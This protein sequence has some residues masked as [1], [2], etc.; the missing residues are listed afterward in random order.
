MKWLHKYSPLA[1]RAIF[2]GHIALIAGCSGSGSSGPNI[3]LAWENGVFRSA[4]YYQGY[5]SLEAQ[6]FFLRSLFN[7]FY[8]WYTDIIDADPLSFASIPEHFDYLV[9]DDITPSGKD[10]DAYSTYVDSLIF[11]LALGD[12][13]E[14]GYGLRLT[15]VDNE[16]VA[17]V[18]FIAN[19]SPASAA[20]LKR[21][22][23]IT[24]IDGYTLDNQ[25]AID[26]LYPFYTGETHTLTYDELG[27]ASG[28]AI[29]LVS[30]P[31]AMPATGSRDIFQAN[32]G[33]NIVDVG[34]LQF[35]DHSAISEHE[36]I[37]HFGY[38]ETAGI[39]ELILD[40][41]YNSGGYL[42][43]ASQVAYMIAG[44]TATSSAIF[45]KLLFNDRFA[46][47]DISFETTGYNVAGLL[48][49]LPTL[50]LGR[51]IIIS[52]EDTCSA[53]ESIINGLRG[54][55]VDVVL[56]GDTTCGKPYGFYGF[57]NCGV[58]YLPVAFEGV[59]NLYAGTIDDSNGGYKDGF[60]PSQ[61]SD[62][63]ALSI[64]GCAVDDDFNSAIGNSGESRLAAALYFLENNDSC[65]ATASNLSS[66]IATTA[67][68]SQPTVH[69]SIKTKR[70]NRKVM[71]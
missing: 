13:I 47:E 21:G 8:Y 67:A 50:D 58:T 11:D 52:G 28:Q 53:S 10:K 7:E 69:P 26:A 66:G 14:I 33:G 2:A 6:Q 70:L 64:N 56:V 31:V 15:Y 45:E 35:N 30:E 43:I 41:R 51:V 22:D 40:L 38:F 27:G 20:G 71:R 37:E 57:D 29:N 19:N 60:K 4:G 24:H 17:T 49:N 18:A 48:V 9:S 16:N 62:I 54:V 12:S 32:I 3:D 34:Y 65:P 61:S 55:G 23:R 5:C 42:Y 63:Y 68:Q 44:A 39:D 46:N 36:L 59:N 1:L 25:Q